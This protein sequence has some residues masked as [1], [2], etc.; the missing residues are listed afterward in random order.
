MQYDTH[1]DSHRGIEI[2]NSEKKNLIDNP[3]T[4]CNVLSAHRKLH[5]TIVIFLIATH[6]IAYSEYPN[7]L[8]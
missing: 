2:A 5:F 7:F 6:K 1:F 4:L 3:C 8:S